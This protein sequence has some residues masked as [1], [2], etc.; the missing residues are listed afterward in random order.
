MTC[1][2]CSN[3]CGTGGWTGP[4]P[5]D[6]DNNSVLTATPAFGGIEV[7]WTYPTVNPQAV[8]HV[9]LYRGTSSNF[10]TAV[11]LAVATG[12]LYFDRIED[13]HQYWYWIKIVSVNGTVG[14]LLG[15]ATA[16]SE[17]TINQIITKLAGK[18]TASALNQAL[19]TEID[20][21]ALNAAD[22]TA[23]I[24]NRLSAS[25]ALTNALAQV[26][27]GITQAI[28]LINTEI[29]QR[30]E[31]DSALVHQVN[32]V[33]AANAANAAAIITE[34]DARVISEGA[35]A[36]TVSGVSSVANGA[37]SAASTAQQTADAA[38]D[39]ATSAL[40]QLTN[41]ASDNILSPAEK[42][43][44]VAAYGVI[45]SEKTGILDEATRYSIT[46]EKTAYSD[47]ITALTTYLTDL[48]GWNVLPGNDVTIVGATFRSKFA[49]VYSARQTL[50]NKISEK[51]K[52]FI[53]DA[54]QAADDAQA[55]ADTAN[56]ALADIASD[57][58]LSPNE[59][60]SIVQAYNV[61]ID[62]K[63]GIVAEGTRYGIVGEKTAYTTAVTALTDYLDG[64]IG[65]NDVP[66]S[67][68]TIVGA[69]FRSKFADVYATRQTLLNAIAAKAKSLI[70]TAQTKADQV[71]ADISST[72]LAKA[73]NPDTYASA[74]AIAQ[75]INDVRVAAGNAGAAI[76]TVQSAKIGY[77]ALTPAYPYG[78][79]GSLPPGATYEYAE[80]PYDGDGSTIVY[81]AALYSAS[82]YP[83]YAANRTRIIDK[84]GVI[85]WNATTAGAAKP[86]TWVTGLPLAKAISTAQ[87]TNAAGARVSVQQAF[88]AQ[89]TT[90]SGLLGQYTLKIDNNGMVAGFGLA[91][92]T[93]N[94]TVKSSFMVRADSFS[95]VN[96]N[97]TRTVSSIGID[98]DSHMNFVSAFVTSTAHG[99][100][101]GDVVQFTGLV[102]SSNVPF[103]GSATVVAV[104]STTRFLVNTLLDS[105]G[106][107]SSGTKVVKAAVPFI[108][109]DGKVYMD[110]AII[111]NASIDFA[112]MNT[113]S[114]NELSSINANM[115]TINAG[116]IR[117]DQPGAAV[118][119][120]FII[121]D[122]LTQTI[123]V[124][125]GGHL[126][127]KIGNLA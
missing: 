15:P 66:G 67:S 83:E 94:G 37:A 105:Y 32:V 65:W 77:S 24:N 99:L 56:N 8:A 48:V 13:Q 69:T 46:T 47:A 76:S 97:A 28:T 54:Q 53:A 114:I 126:R 18:I 107:S 30:T 119:T 118:D 35:I 11:Q 42:P 27:S 16:T 21:I 111:K 34:H 80:I 7:S 73:E 4:L 74:S 91:S 75:K 90:N 102:T 89:D 96:P 49:D 127:V 44:I 71:A 33:A 10:S 104:T 82:A 2:T 79:V 12:T 58:K 60:P 108:V 103:T 117:F 5:G 68:I 3:A 121:M 29:T 116:T 25:G 50:L 112:K 101:V 6:P 19:K 95:I 84:Q 98:S 61:I 125:S 17:P 20:K 43:S 57:S 23:E 59:K 22:L 36:L 70:S 109:E 85:N 106:I 86:L 88:T 78:F 110:S 52:S 115:G 93:V 124:F 62:E 92:S 72:E 63:V 39:D 122:S 9:L 14:E 40:D 45:T 100:V 87:I 55:D 81:P 38:Q 51:A 31:G 113:A 1:E 123:R 26:Q 41:L 64:L 120:N